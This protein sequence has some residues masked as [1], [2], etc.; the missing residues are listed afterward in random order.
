MPTL[1]LVRHG[2]SLWNLENRFTG[3]VDVPL[4]PTGE[5]EAR[6]AGQRLGDAGL[7]FDIAYTSALRRAQDTLA[8]LMET[9]G[10]DL[11]VIRDEALNERH[12]GDLQGLN[13][14]QTAERYGAD[15]VHT[16][17]RSFATPPPNG[18]S[19]EMTAART[20]PF[21]QRAILGDIALG[22]DVLVVAH[23]N[24]NR[25]IVMQLDTLDEEGVLSLELATGVPLVYDLA[26]DG[27][28]QG[29]RTLQ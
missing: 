1:A 17:R 3:W 11:P 24:S 15:Q 22:K 28:V 25:S 9:A 13:K 20:L 18:E 19:L 23:G 12:Y 6:D 26:D 4:T 7:S 2:Q 14:A 29:K 5:Q 16:W 8:L 21:F 10:Y 27:T